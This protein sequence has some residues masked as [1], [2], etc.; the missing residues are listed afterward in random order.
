MSQVA[1][2]LQDT[3]LTGGMSQ[4]ADLLQDPS[5]MMV[6]EQSKKPRR[7]IFGKYQC[8]ARDDLKYQ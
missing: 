3:S 7:R 5:L 2:L 1:D 4:V 8:C 6:Q